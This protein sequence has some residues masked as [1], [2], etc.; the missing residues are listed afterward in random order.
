MLNGWPVWGDQD[1]SPFLTTAAPQAAPSIVNAGE[2]GLPVFG[3]E[4]SS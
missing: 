1:T 2:L 4:G 3:Q